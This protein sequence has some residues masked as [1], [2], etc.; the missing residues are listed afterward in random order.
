[1]S[2]PT[3]SDSFQRLYC[4][5]AV[6]DVFSTRNPISLKRALPFQPQDRVVDDP[7]LINAELA[8]LAD[9]NDA[10]RSAVID[11]YARCGLL[12][13]TDAANV[14]SVIDFF[15]VDFFDLMGLVY[16]NA[17]IYICALRWYRE[18]IAELETQDPDSRS[19]IKSVYASVGYSLYALGMFE[20]AIA[21]TKSCIGPRLV[22]DTACRA[23]IEYE[24]RQANGRLLAT[25]RS[26]SD[27]QIRTRYT[28]AVP[29][30]SLASQIGPP[31][32]AALETLAPFQESYLSWVSNAAPPLPIQ[33]GYPFRIERD[34]G[35]FPRH[36]M[37][38]LFATCGQAD[39]LIAG[40]FVSEARRLL[41]EAAVLEPNASFIQE[42]IQMLG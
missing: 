27:R 32:K 34:N 10:T 12:S 18:H 24:A 30:P 25:E 26:S 21:W 2:V 8:H 16:A 39:A 14:K 36:K 33:E 5:A 35:N 19:D 9:K 40:G 42:R 41:S 29:D 3:F 31:L 28:I 4:D 37:N 20:E 38:L 17:G 13:D 15:G 6:F 1:M 7:Y 11:A 23:L 22:T